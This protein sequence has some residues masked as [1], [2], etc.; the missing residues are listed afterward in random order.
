MEIKP[1]TSLK[2]LTKQTARLAKKHKRKEQIQV[3]IWLQLQT[4]KKYFVIELN[5][6]TQRT[7]PSTKNVETD[8]RRNVN[9]KWLDIYLRIQSSS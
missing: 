9:P 2:K 1:N 5:T 4:L 7:N 3:K 6:W 8:S